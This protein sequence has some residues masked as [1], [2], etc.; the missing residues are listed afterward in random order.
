MRVL[1]DFLEFFDLKEHFGVIDE[2]F[3]DFGADYDLISEEDHGDVFDDLSFEKFKFFDV[4]GFLFDNKL[5]LEVVVFDYVG[6]I[7]FEELLG[8]DVEV[9]VG[10]VHLIVYSVFDQFL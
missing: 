10:F 3:L 5:D 1:E 9:G 6:V 2:M 8:V 4:G 7:D